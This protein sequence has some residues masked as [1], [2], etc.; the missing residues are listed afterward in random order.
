M[1]ILFI[2][3]MSL[4]KEKTAGN[5]VHFL[6]IGKALQALHHQVILVAPFYQ[7]TGTRFHYGLTDEQISLQKKD[8]SH[9][10][11]FHRLLEEKLPCF[12]DRYHPD[13]VYSRDL[14]NVPQISHLAHRSGLPHMVEI[15]GLLR[16]E[17]LLQR[18][19]LFPLE[20]GQNKAI[21]SA[22]L[23][24]V[25]TNQQKN[26]LVQRFGRKPSEVFCIPQGTDPTLYHDLGKTNARQRLQ[27]PL[28]TFLFTF[29]GSLNFKTYLKGLHAFL[30]AF[31]A[32]QEKHPDTLLRI[33]GDG[34]GKKTL[35][36]KIQK[37]GMAAKVQ[38]IGH[39]PNDQVPLH[40]CA[41]DI[42]IQPWVPEFPEKEEL[43]IKLPAYMACERR[44][45]VTNIP[46]FRDVTK[47]FDPLL[48]NHLQKGSM[49]TCLERAWKE[50]DSWNKGKEQREFIQKNLTWEISAKKIMQAISEGSQG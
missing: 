29:V 47:G 33:V 8:F 19:R 46:G 11:K 21:A 2:T 32:F 24:R 28:D 5:K 37:W 14:L 17:T 44:V 16:E 18:A 7:N 35:Q 12:L 34:K 30:E 23:L 22:D 31:A 49:N 27:L 26:T 6:G 15:N 1:V 50:K 4:E 48:W 43:S 40:V 45:L 10:W 38:F 13:L 25:M 42:C 9:F 39:V 41:S 36:E 20:R 3:S